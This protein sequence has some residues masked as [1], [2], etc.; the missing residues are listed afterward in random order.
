MNVFLLSSELNPELLAQ[1]AFLAAFT[2]GPNGGTILILA[3][4]LAV[5]YVTGLCIW[6]EDRKRF[7]EAAKGNAGLQAQI[8]VA[9][10]ARS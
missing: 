5:G 1:A 10:S 9:S 3:L 2:T 6:R 7:H 4:A 8:D